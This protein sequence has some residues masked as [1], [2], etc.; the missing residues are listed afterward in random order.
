MMVSYWVVV[1]IATLWV[2][3]M[4]AL[5]IGLKVVNRPVPAP[6]V[7]SEKRKVAVRVW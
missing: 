4:T 5:L 1:T 2:V 3:C 6:E 7:K